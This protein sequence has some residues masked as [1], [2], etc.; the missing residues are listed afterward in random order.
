MPSASCP[1]APPW[2]R[3]CQSHTEVPLGLA[4]RANTAVLGTD[5]IT[6]KEFWRQNC[7]FWEKQANQRAW[8]AF[9]SVSMTSSFWV[10]SGV[11]ITLTAVDAPAGGLKPTVPPNGKSFRLLLPSASGRLPPEALPGFV[12]STFTCWQQGLCSAWH[13]HPTLLKWHQGTAKWSTE[14]DGEIGSCGWLGHE[15]PLPSRTFS[16]TGC[17]C[18]HYYIVRL[19]FLG[20]EAGTVRWNYMVG[21]CIGGRHPTQPRNLFLL[22]PD[23]APSSFSTQVAL[24]NFPWGFI[25][26]NITSFSI[27]EY[28]V[29][30]VEIM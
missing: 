9:P 5:W 27:I 15:S 19:S 18:L 23:P 1:F 14:E 17:K 22:N 3:T 16:P 26:L 7:C 21:T 4:V 28:E 29:K 12:P 6:R 11:W 13:S 8:L 10:E 25:P 24:W 20:L 30:K 2:H